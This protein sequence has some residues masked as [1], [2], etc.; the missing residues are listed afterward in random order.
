MYKT[1]MT[2]STG[3]FCA[4]DISMFSLAFISDQ[5]KLKT[6]FPNYHLSSLFFKKMI[7]ES[8]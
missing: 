7:N 8:F 6:F 5:E 2:A 3:L 1:C 4:I